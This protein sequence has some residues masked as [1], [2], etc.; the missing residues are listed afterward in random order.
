MVKERNEINK[1]QVSIIDWGYT[2]RPSETYDM[3]DLPANK[4]TAET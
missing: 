2:K 4:L 3:R 1:V